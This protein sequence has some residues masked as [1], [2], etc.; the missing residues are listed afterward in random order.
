MIVGVCFVLVGNQ[1]TF[2]NTFTKCTE[3]NCEIQGEINDGEST[4]VRSMENEFRLRL[5]SLTFVFASREQTE[6]ERREAYTRIELLQSEIERLKDEVSQ[7]NETI[8]EKE[9]VIQDNQ[10]KHHHQILLER[11][12]I[13]ER[14]SNESKR[15]TELAEKSVAFLLLFYTL[16]AL[17]RTRH[18]EGELERFQR[19]QIIDRR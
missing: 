11:H 17:S 8:V 18:L 14:I 4:I 6:R 19:N 9:K 16:P 3:Y 15:F 2:G 7:K 5:N 10:Y 12:S 13:E 1:C